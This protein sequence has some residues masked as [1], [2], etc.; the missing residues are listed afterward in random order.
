MTCEGMTIHSVTLLPGNSEVVF[1]GLL[2]V[3]QVKLP[4]AIVVATVGNVSGAVVN[5]LLGRAG[6][7]AMGE[8]GSHDLIR[9]ER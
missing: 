5:Y 2:V 8:R 6:R 7:A 1:A 9:A 4:V 3:S